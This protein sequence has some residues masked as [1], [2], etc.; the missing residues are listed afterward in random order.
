MHLVFEIIEVIGKCQR[1]DGYIHTPVIIDQ[2]EKKSQAG[3]F[4]NRMDFETYNMGH[5]M[6]CACVHYR[7]TGKTSLLAI[8]KKAADYLS[9]IAARYSQAVINVMSSVVAWILAR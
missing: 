9:E 2:R 8:A 7:A 3:E 4:S 5:L 1:E 6:T